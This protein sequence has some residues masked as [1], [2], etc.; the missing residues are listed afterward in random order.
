MHDGVNPI[1]LSLGWEG[2]VYLAYSQHFLIVSKPKTLLE[3]DMP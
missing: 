2:N 1:I 3:S